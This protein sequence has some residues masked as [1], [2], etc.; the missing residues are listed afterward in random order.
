MAR[1][2]GV[3]QP[4]LL[5]SPLP[6]LTSAHVHISRPSSHRSTP[7]QSYLH[8]NPVVRSRYASCHTT[9]ASTFTKGI[10][11]EVKRI[12]YSVSRGGKL[13]AEVMG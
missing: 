7:S 1:G 9:E 2:E 10:T 12:T 8:F 13:F 6:P 3:T 5:V 11:E 4:T